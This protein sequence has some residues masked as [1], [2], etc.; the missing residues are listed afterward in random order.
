MVSQS[1]LKLCLFIPV[2]AGIYFP[3]IMLLDFKRNQ[4][5]EKSHHMH[6]EKR[7]GKNIE[8]HQLKLCFYLAITC[9]PKEVP[10]QK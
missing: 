3:S 6:T 9:N 7:E 8:Y 1:F 4:T 2:S 10:P 5:Q